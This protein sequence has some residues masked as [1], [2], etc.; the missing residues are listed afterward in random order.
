MRGDWQRGDVL[1]GARDERGVPHVRLHLAQ[2][3]RI[4][5]TRVDFVSPFFHISPLPMLPTRG[6]ADSA[7]SA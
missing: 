2:L 3:L 1:V 7:K 5:H 4:L 6:R